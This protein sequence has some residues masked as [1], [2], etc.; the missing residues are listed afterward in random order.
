MSAWRALA[1]AGTLMLAALVA[2]AAASAHATLKSTSPARGATLTTQPRHVVL[3]FSETV[4]GNFG[5]LRVFDAAAKR[6]DDGRTVHPGGTG[7]Q[8]AVGLRPGLPDGSYVATYRIVSADGHPVAG[9]LVFSIGKPGASATP[10]VSELIGATGA[11][12]ATQIAFAVARGATYLATALLLGGLPFVLFIWLPATRAVGGE[13]GA[14]VARL[15]RLLLGG[16]ALGV[17]AGLVGLVCQGATA[18]ATSVWSALD[19]G[20]IGDVLGTRF[21]HVWGLR[22]LAFAVLAIAVTRA[23]RRSALAFAAV[24]AGFLACAPALAGHASVTAPVWLLVA[25][26]VGH[27]VAMSLWIGGLVM[28]VTVLPAATRRL[29]GPDRT[30][31]LSAC[32]CASRHSRW[33]ASACCCS[34]ARTRRSSTSTPGAS[35]RTRASAARCSSS[36]GC[37]SC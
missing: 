2:P 25:L 37:S 32:L 27:V 29:D 33:A 1:V 9:G 36:L 7:S 35:S 4:E 10:T 24:P 18:G 19:P 31:L 6:V 28:L 3:R 8:L 5:A 22:V 21:G 23:P 12:P 14:F 16:A 26:D 30:R 13:H 11:G 17:L 34:P 20:V 15:R